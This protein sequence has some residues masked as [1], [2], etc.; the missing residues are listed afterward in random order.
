ML[1]M[2]IEVRLGLLFLVG[3]VMGRQ[4]NRGIYSLAWHRRRVGPWSPAPCQAASR[5]W[6]DRLPV[7]GWWRL[8]REA[9]WHGRGYWI[10]PLLIELATGCGFALLYWWEVERL[11]LW[12]AH[13]IAPAAWV[14]HA[15]YLSHILLIC[16]MIVA[17]FIDF[18]EQTIPDGITVTGTVLG[19]LLAAS[20]PGSLLPTTFHPPLGTATMH[21][22]VVVSST[23]SPRW[24]DGLGGPFSWPRWLNSAAGVTLALFGVWAWCLAILHKTWTMRRGLCRALRYMVASIVRRRTW[25]LPLILGLS[26]S[27][28]VIA[29]WW[30]STT[31]AGADHWQALFSA[32]AGMCFGGGLIWTVRIIAGEALQVEAMGFGDVTLMA[33]IGAFLGWQAAFLVFFLAPFTALLIALAQRILTGNPRIAFGPYLCLSTLIVLLAWDPMWGHWA[34]LMFS[35]GWLIPGMLACCLVLMGVLLWFWRVVRDAFL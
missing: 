17:T 32:I 30:F 34:R 13:A 18:D 21:H 7:V 19:L 24:E 16:L 27:A 25:Q 2:P 14:V 4:I 15:Q 11:I 6:S 33:M 28:V 29:S 22:V 3:L 12:P 35:F 5:H 20:L 9:T 23:I 8:R 10:R 26:L 31:E 1:N